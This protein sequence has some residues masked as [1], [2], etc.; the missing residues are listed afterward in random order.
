MR[1]RIRPTSLR[2]SVTQVDGVT[3]L[4]G[5]SPTRAESLQIVHGLHARYQALTKR[6]KDQQ[7]DEVAK[8]MGVYDTDFVLID[9]HFD[10][11]EQ[12]GLGFDDVFTD[13]PLMGV[14]QL[15]EALP[16]E[17]L[18]Q[19]ILRIEQCQRNGEEPSRV[20]AATGTFL[21]Q[22]IRYS[23]M[24]RSGTP[25]PQIFQ[26]LGIPFPAQAKFSA[27]RKRLSPDR[28]LGFLARCP[29]LELR[30]RQTYRGPEMLA[31]EFI[32]LFS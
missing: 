15:I 9:D 26:S 2:K 19:L 21:R 28:V 31:V 27:A 3:S 29:E 1:Y 13:L 7:R 6:P 10:R 12:T 25:E 24:I 32:E 18:P 23:G 17:P 14:Y 11:M 22:F 8:A 20:L 5:Y 16:T 30:I 4:L